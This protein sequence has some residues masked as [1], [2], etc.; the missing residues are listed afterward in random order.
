MYEIP[1]YPDESADFTQVL[2]IESVS[3]T[4]RITY[5]IRNQYFKMRLTTENNDIDGLKC[6]IN[7]PLIYP[8]NALFPELKGDFFI[9]QATNLNE[10]VAFDYT[11]FGTTYK[12][13]YYTEEEVLNWRDENGV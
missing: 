3:L 9:Q 5:N 11:N 7:F 8:H 13:Y 6:V 4:I 1:V 2:D 12:L 10:V